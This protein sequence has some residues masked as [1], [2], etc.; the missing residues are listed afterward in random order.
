[1]LQ[2][3]RQPAPLDPSETESHP[4]LTSAQNPLLECIRI[5]M[6]AERHLV[7]RAEP[8]PDHQACRRLAFAR[9]LRLTARITEDLD[10]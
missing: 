9:W 5:T 10:S 6:A 7:A 2:I 1:M 8:C 3:F 4:R